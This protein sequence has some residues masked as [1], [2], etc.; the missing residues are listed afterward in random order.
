MNKYLSFFCFLIILISLCS[1][2]LPSK[3]NKAQEKTSGQ[4]VETVNTDIYIEVGQE[5]QNDI[6]AMSI[7]K[8]LIASMADSKDLGISYNL[9]EKSGNVYFIA[10]GNVKNVSSTAFSLSSL[11][12]VKLLFDGKYE[13]SVTMAPSDIMN[14]VPL[15]TESFIWYSSVP[16]EVFNSTQKYDFVWNWNGHSDSGVKETFHFEGQNSQYLSAENIANFHAFTEAIEYVLANHKNIKYSINEEYEYIVVTWRYSFKMNL[17]DVPDDKVGFYNPRYITV[18]PKLYLYYSYFQDRQKNSTYKY[19]YG[20]MNVYLE[21]AEHT[22]VTYNK[23]F[24]FS[25]SAGTINLEGQST[26]R[27]FSDEHWWMFYIKDDYNNALA[28][29]DLWNVTNGANLKATVNYDDTNL[30]RDGLQTSAVCDDDWKN[31]MITLL[32]IYSECPLSTLNIN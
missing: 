19:G 4:P 13:Y 9:P 28:L 18:T 11:I 17:P 15:K 32:Q 12:D 24:T 1:C 25:S 26:P 2:N 16:L 8:T 6:L 14:V 22:Y 20:E 5:I 29:H 30:D 3:T 21:R 23:P 10:F 7:N 27:L 31:A